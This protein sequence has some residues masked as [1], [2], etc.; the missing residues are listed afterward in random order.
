MISMTGYGY[1]EYR[2]DRVELLTEIKS[3][4]NRYL[5]IT[6]NT[7]PF[8]SPLEPVI[9]DFVR[10]RVTR[11]R[12]DVTLRVKELEE[13]IT[14]H[15]DDK[16]VSEYAEALRRIAEAAG[17]QDEPRISHFLRLEGVLNQ[18][19]N[20]DL[21]WFEG[22]V[23]NQL[24]SSYEDFAEAKRKEGEATKK[25]ILALVETVEHNLG[26]IESHARTLD[27]KIRETLE[28]RFRE[29]VGESMDEN[30]LYQE[31]AVMLVKYGI[32]EETVRMRSHIVQFRELLDEV[33]GVGKKLDFVC[34]EL[35]REINTIGSKSTVS[36]INRSV[37]EV[38]DALEKIREQL[39]NVE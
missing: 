2:D 39:R 32:D 3:Y 30:R 28:T 5:D 7:P 24:S 23:M 31:T 37:V 17:L 38:K 25:D 27:E 35:N 12:V 1:R 9:K 10:E 26:R 19:K 4:N 20:R 16:T 8:L 18:V 29:L 11:G 22:I 21:E 15:V 6:V 34:Q 14:V 13:D 33:T 36:E